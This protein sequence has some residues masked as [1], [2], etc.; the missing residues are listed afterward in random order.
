[1]IMSMPSVF[2]VRHSPIQSLSLDHI[3]PSS[4]IYSCVLPIASEQASLGISDYAAAAGLSRGRWSLLPTVPMPTL[5]TTR[6]TQGNDVH[7]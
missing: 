1:M 3:F 7:V 4:R 6:C 5:T 2:R